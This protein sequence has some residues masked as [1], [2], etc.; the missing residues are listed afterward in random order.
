[1]LYYVSFPPKYY[2]AG[3]KTSEKRDFDQILKFYVLLY[4]NPIRRSGQI[5]HAKV[6]VVYGVKKNKRH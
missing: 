6:P 2:L 1:M 5:W 4:T 3:R